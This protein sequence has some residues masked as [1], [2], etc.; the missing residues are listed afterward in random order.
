M[1]PCTS[2]ATF[3]MN[4]KKKRN[5]KFNT[6][7]SAGLSMSW[8]DIF[9]SNVFLFVLNSTLFFSFFC[10][11]RRQMLRIGGSLLLYLC[12][13]FCVIILQRGKTIEWDAEA[14]T[15]AEG[16]RVNYVYLFYWFSC[17]SRWESK[18]FQKQTVA[19][20]CVWDD[21]CAGREHLFSF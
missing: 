2:S 15:G 7:Q 16:E 3:P 4:N 14:G 5:I 20:R 6:T 21:V 13:S 1:L 17:I 18:H 9:L 10:F 8:S 12:L 19:Y 11:A